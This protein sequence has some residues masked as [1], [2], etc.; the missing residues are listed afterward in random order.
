MGMPSLPPTADKESQTLLIP[1]PRKMRLPGPDPG[2][3]EEELKELTVKEIG[4]VLAGT[5]RK[6][7]IVV[8]AGLADI[9]VGEGGLP[10][11]WE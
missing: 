9:K 8:E 10:P 7:W 3:I 1:P 2:R 6:P 5:E 11:V 4:T